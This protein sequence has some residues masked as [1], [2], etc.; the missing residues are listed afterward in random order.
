MSRGFDIID[1]SKTLIQGGAMLIFFIKAHLSCITARVRF[2]LLE[3]DPT[4]AG[5][6]SDNGVFICVGNNLLPIASCCIN[7]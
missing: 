5:F 3:C 4:A 7:K 2:F 6:L 1:H